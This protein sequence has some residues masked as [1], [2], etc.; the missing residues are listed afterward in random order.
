MRGPEAP[1]GPLGSL[2][3]RRGGD[4]T[5][6][7]DGEAP[8]RS[9]AR[10]L[11]LWRHARRRITTTY[12]RTTGRPMMRRLVPRGPA[13]AGAARTNIWSLWWVDVRPSG[14]LGRK[15]RQE[16]GQ[17][18][19][20]SVKLLRTARPLS[21]VVFRRSAELRCESVEM[22]TRTAARGGVGVG[23]AGSRPTAGFEHDDLPHVWSPP[24]RKSP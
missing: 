19:G 10:A 13:R 21:N 17:G 3:R 18:G 2:S 12:P 20:D 11:A 22:R 7:T 8:A 1:L 4:A 23:V 14:A 15:G 24:A 6:A 5:T 16:W 9:L